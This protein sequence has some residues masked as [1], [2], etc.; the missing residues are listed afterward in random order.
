[1]KPT[2]EQDEDRGTRSSKGI[3]REERSGEY[4]SLD[5]VVRATGHPG[6]DPEGGFANSAECPCMGDSAREV[7]EE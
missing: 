2:R 5:G 7:I 3:L 1:M 4:V 6:A